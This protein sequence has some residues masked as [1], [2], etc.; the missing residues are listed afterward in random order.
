M[1]RSRDRGVSTVLDAALAVL[2]VTGAV[3]VLVDAPPDPQSPRTDATHVA[4]TVLPSTVSV[5]SPGAP[6]VHGSFGALLAAAAGPSAPSWYRRG[7]REAGDSL[8][9][10]LA[11]PA[12]V[13]A[14]SPWGAELA[15]GPA[16]PPRSPVDAAVLSL[17]T[18]AGTVDIVVRVWRG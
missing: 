9:D 12:N 5:P 14:V 7:V 11:T 13:S 16:P 10:T 15:V 8:L 4:A 17:R 1:T 18:S 2:L 6:T 3:T